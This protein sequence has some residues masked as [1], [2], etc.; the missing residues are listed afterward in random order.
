MTTET[1]H[2]R[3][4]AALLAR[5]LDYKD[6]ISVTGLSKP[7][8]Y[9]WKVDANKRST[10]MD[11]D[12]AALVCDFL[13]IHPLWLF[14]GKGASGLEDADESPGRTPEPAKPADSDP[15]DVRPDHAGHYHPQTQ[16]VASMMESLD[17]SARDIA[18]GAVTAALMNAGYKPEVKPLPVKKQR[19]A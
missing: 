6:L 17:D 8:V 13:R 19:R 1:W 16:K 18:L 7:S 3:L 4:A 11:A 14:H 10:M 15:I 12:N 5:K 2:K 9:A